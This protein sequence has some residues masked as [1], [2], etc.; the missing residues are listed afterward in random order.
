MICAY[1]GREDISL[2]IRAETGLVDMVGRTALIYAIIGR[3]C[4][5]INLLLPDEL[6]I[7]DAVGNSFLHYMRRYGIG[8]DSISR[9]N[10]LKV[11]VWMQELQRK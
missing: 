8:F 3:R 6:R 9:V 7:L 2:L 5:L 11:S 1:I 4:A 10:Q